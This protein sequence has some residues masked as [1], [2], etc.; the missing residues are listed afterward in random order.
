VDVRVHIQ[1]PIIDV[2]ADDKKGGR[3]RIEYGLK[4]LSESSQAVLLYLTRK[5]SQDDF[6]NEIAEMFSNSESLPHEVK[7]PAANMDQRLIGTGSQILRALGVKRMRVHSSSH[8]PYIGL[9]GFG[10]EVVD[11]KP[12]KL[13]L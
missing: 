8:T 4:T 10:L 3:F 9:S 5:D 2:F 7:I 6:E 1:R 13:E 11:T 12:V